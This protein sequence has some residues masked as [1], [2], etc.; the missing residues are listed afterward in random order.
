MKRYIDPHH[1]FTRSPPLRHV[2]GFP[3]CAAAVVCAAERRHLAPQG[4]GGASAP[5][6]LLGFAGGCLV[7]VLAGD[8]WRYMIMINYN[9]AVVRREQF[10][11]TGHIPC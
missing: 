9:Y 2:A 6:G 5:H 11:A 10:G 3:D 8:L 1:F 7:G 4:V